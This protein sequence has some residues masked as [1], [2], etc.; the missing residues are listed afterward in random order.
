MEC[1]RDAAAQAMAVAQEASLAGDGEKALRFARKSLALFSTPECAALLL[2][3]EATLHS[4]PPARAAAP[5]HAPP[6]P[7]APSGASA[8]APAR[9]PK[10]SELV[11]R[12]MGSRTLYDV[13]GVARGAVETEI[14]KAYRRLA[15]QLHPDKNDE[16][17]AEEA[18][19][20]VGEAVQTL[21]D[22]GKRYAYDMQTDAPP[23]HAPRHTAFWRP[24]P[25]RWNA[26]DYASMAAR[27]PPPRPPPPRQYSFPMPTGALPPGC[28]RTSAFDITCTACSSKLRVE[29]PNHV[30]FVRMQYPVECPT[31]NVCS[32]VQVNPFNWPSAAGGHAAAGQSVRRSTSN[33]ASM[34]TPSKKPTKAEE[35]AKK[36]AAAEAARQKKAEAA[37]ARAEAAKAKA[38]EK[39]KVATKKRKRAV[40]SESEEE[41]EDSYEEEDSVSEHSAEEIGE[42]GNSSECWYCKD[43]GDLICC[44]SCPRSFHFECLVPPM[45][46]A[47]M[48]EGDWFCPLCTIHKEELE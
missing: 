12:I 3:I 26:F 39:R 7:A 36:R 27:P 40:E 19:K 28:P 2:R 22:V 6:R 38:A 46:H 35:Q 37:K 23:L 31:C 47:D 21:T 29:L 33:E 18:F 10:Y 24:P 5:P 14:R 13:L 9:P 8:S 30:G 17:G 1:N 45:R 43:G 34:P 42:D 11:Q 20:R 25:R 32:Q 48:P 15:V 41:E 16:P 44:D 4:S